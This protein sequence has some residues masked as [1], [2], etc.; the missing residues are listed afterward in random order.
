MASA[1]TEPG[2]APFE[3]AASLGYV[4]NHLARMFAHALD[5]RLAP[6]NVARGQ[7]PLLLI[8]WEEEGLTQTEIARRL[9]IE[10][11]TVANTLRRME[12]D[13]FVA[14]APDPSNRRQVLVRLT[15][16][17]RA[18]RA[19]VIAGAR[20]VN[21]RAGASLTSDELATFMLLLDKMRAAFSVE[22]DVQ[23]GTTDRVGTP[24]D[25]AR[26]ARYT[27]APERDIL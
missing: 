5:H 8:L 20:A 12:R 18:L 1:P 15:E 9:D 14:L 19:P 10:Q 16:K 26:A 2:T 11:P 7:F 27:P 17:S 25:D 4:V 23:L 24:E 21:A 6:Y 3:R 22:Q 13:G